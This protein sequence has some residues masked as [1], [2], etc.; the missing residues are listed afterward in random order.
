MITITD[1]PNKKEPYW[2]VVDS[3]KTENVN[4]PYDPNCPIG[5]DRVNVLRQ[6]VDVYSVMSGCKKQ[7]WQTPGSVFT[8]S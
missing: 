2:E 1:F 4:F 7:A 6:I 3:N 5:Y 8:L